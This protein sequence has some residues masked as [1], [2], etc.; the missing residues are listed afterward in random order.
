M[1][2]AKGKFTLLG[3]FGLMFPLFPLWGQS[4]IDTVKR[5][6][7]GGRQFIQVYSYQSLMEEGYF[8]DGIR[9]G[10]WI[11]Y[12]PESYPSRI[13]TYKGGQKDGLSMEIDPA[14]KVQLVEYYKQGRKEGPR[15]RYHEQGSQI[16]ESAHYHEDLLHGPRIRWY[17]NGERQ[18][19]TNYAHGQL[20]GEARWYS[21]Q[22]VLMAIYHYEKGNLHGACQLFDESGK[23]AE[24]GQYV[25]NEKTG[26]WIRYGPDGQPLERNEYE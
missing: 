3:I 23:L 5:D 11:V 19:E 14:G 25:D 10:V 18:E 16:I 6:D 9:E 2:M 17:D 1:M 13:V 20:Q 26:V 7:G 12:W 24:E 15:K 8:Q 21:P 4:R 22:G